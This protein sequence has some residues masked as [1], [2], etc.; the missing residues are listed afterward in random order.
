MTTK[1]RAL[2]PLGGTGGHVFVGV[3]DALP[4]LKPQR[5]GN[6]TGKVTRIARREIVGRVRHL[7]Q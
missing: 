5:K 2:N 6:R 7:G 3:V 1:P 4:A